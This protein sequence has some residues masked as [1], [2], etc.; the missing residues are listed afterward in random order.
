MLFSVTLQTSSVLL[1]LEVGLSMTVQAACLLWGLI[2]RGG[3]ARSLACFPLLAFSSDA[4]APLLL[5]DF[6]LP[7]DIEF[8]Q[9]SLQV[10]IN[11]IYQ[12]EFPLSANIPSA[13]PA[14]LFFSSQEPWKHRLFKIVSSL[15]AKLLAF[16]ACLSSSLL[17][18][19][20][21]KNLTL[22]S[23]EACNF[24]PTYWTIKGEWLRFFTLLIMQIRIHKT[25][26]G[27]HSF[28]KDPSDLI[29]FNC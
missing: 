24:L 7:I 1:L 26:F 2:G 13:F 21:K 3:W 12:Q 27:L 9:N 11:Q 5:E 22:F 23:N 19:L 14:S 28:I 4:N 6:L 16:I 10:I 29:Y 25:L 20:H 18:N 8:S 15:E 17:G